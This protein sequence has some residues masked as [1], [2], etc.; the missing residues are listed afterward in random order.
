MALL[1]LIAPCLLLGLPAAQ[2][3]PRFGVEVGTPSEATRV[4]HGLDRLLPA[5]EV[6]RVFPDTVAAQRGLR[7]G[8]LL[9]SLEGALIDSPNRFA[10]LIAATAP[11]RLVR[12]VISRH[13]VL[14]RTDQDGNRRLGTRSVDAE[15]FGQW[16]H[17]AGGNAAQQGALIAGVLAPTAAREAGLRVGDLILQVAGNAI[18]SH[19]DLVAAI[20]QL[21]D[22]QRGAIRFERAL[23]LPTAAA[24]AFSSA[25]PADMSHAL[26]GLI[27]GPIDLE[28][29][30]HG[31]LLGVERALLVHGVCDDSPAAAAGLRVWDLL[32]AFDGDDAPLAS[33]GD[34]LHRIRQLPAGRAVPIV[35]YRAVR[36]PAGGSGAERGKALGLRATWDRA[37]GG[38][39]IGAVEPGSIAASVGLRAGLAV[40]RVQGES[41]RSPDDWP[42]YLDHVQPG[43]WLWIGLRL[44]LLWL[45][46]TVDPRPAVDVTLSAAEL[47]AGE[48]LTASYICRN[49]PAG[50]TTLALQVERDGVPVAAP[51]TSRTVLAGDEASRSFSLPIPTG[52]S[53]GSYALCVTLGEGAR[54]WTGKSTFTVRR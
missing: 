32:V 15:P 52:A 6:T 19:A 17:Q 21:T 14:C 30:H 36:A 26:L 49:L 42:E 50:E 4:A 20:G 9:L 7:T 53:P 1:R 28:K 23:R 51:V 40:V 34:L 41:V 12:V 46:V 13:A 18:R 54:A 3:Q 33:A 2:D 8:D 5:V 38:L 48:T 47:A 35:V 29:E 10:D 16:E 31:E 22:G 44:D 43:E 11:G 39:T 25:V 24:G 45:P 37:E 27:P